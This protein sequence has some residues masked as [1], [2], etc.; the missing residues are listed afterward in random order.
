M[1]PKFSH[2]TTHQTLIKLST[3]HSKQVEYDNSK[4]ECSYNFISHTTAEFL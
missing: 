4:F 2:Q 1:Q 3:V